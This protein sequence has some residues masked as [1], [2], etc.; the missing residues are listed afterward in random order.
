MKICNSSLLLPSIHSLVSHLPG[1][2]P[3][4]QHSHISHTERREK[5]SSYPGEE[6]A[7]REP[8]KRKLSIE[9]C[10]NESTIFHALLSI[11]WIVPLYWQHTTRSKQ[12]SLI[13][14]IVSL[15]PLFPSS[16][17]L[18]LL[19]GQTSNVL[20]WESWGN[21]SIGN[22]KWF[23]AR[24]HKKVCSTALKN[25]FPSKIIHNPPFARPP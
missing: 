21:R 5:P 20:R 1:F 13:S 3:P 7:T 22:W 16:R 11:S 17:S 24:L 8:S 19:N 12:F 4:Y 9:R 10:K 25:F 23:L 15:F 14:I 2:S 18:W 6:G